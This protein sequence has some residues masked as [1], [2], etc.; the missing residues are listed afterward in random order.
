MGMR[1][2]LEMFAPGTGEGTPEWHPVM[3]DSSTKLT[4]STQDDL[5]AWLTLFRKS[6]PDVKLRKVDI[7]D[8]TYRA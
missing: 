6:Q 4:F 7:V 5:V 3:K 8:R 1:Y 2:G